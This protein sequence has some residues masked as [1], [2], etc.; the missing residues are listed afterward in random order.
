MECCCYSVM[1]CCGLE[2]LPEALH[3]DTKV[4]HYCAHRILWI[5]SYCTLG[6]PLTY[7]HRFVVAVAD[8]CINSDQMFYVCNFMY[9]IPNAVGEVKLNFVF[10]IFQFS[11]ILNVN[12]MSNHK[13]WHYF[14]WDDILP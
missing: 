7:I 4:I 1:E 3:Q 8:F 11:Q 10:R 9:S 14:V 2:C 12:I 13:N 5:Q 6:I